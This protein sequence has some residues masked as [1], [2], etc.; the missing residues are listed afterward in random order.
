[1]T[2]SQPDEFTNFE[3]VQDDKSG[4]NPDVKSDLNRQNENKDVQETVRETWGGEFEFVLSL[5]GY[6]V[7]LGNIWRF[8]YFC[9]KNGGGCAIIPFILFLTVCGGPLYY[10]EVCLGQWSGTSPITVWNICPLLKGLGLLMVSLSLIYIWYYAAAFSWVIY[11]LIQSF[12]PTLPWSKCGNSWN[13]ELCIDAS[14]NITEKMLNMT[15]HGLNTSINF[16]TSGTEYFER[17]VLRKSSGIDTVGPVHLPLTGCFFLGWLFVFLCLAKG[18]KTLGKVVYVTVTLP[19]IL[20]TVLLIRGVTLDGAW[21]GLQHYFIPDFSKLIHGQVWMEAAV[22]CF[23]SLGPA[24]GGAITMASFNKFNH[25]A[26]RD[27]VVVCFADAFTGIYSGVVVFSV[28]GF[29]SKET[30]TPLNELPFSGASLAFIAYPEALSR[31]PAPHVWSVLFFLTLVLVGIDTQ[32]GCFETVT[33]AV[34]DLNYKKLQKYRLLISAGLVTFLFI[35]GL[36]LT[37]SAGYY[38]FMLIDSYMGT[39]NLVGTAL[40]ECIVIAWIYGANRFSADIEMMMGSRPSLILRIIWCFIIPVFLLGILIPTIVTYST[41]TVGDYKFPSHANIVG[42]VFAFAPISLIFIVAIYQV[43]RQRVSR[44]SVRNLLKPAS[45]WLPN[46]LKQRKIYK[47]TTYE[48]ESGFR[49][50]LLDNILGIK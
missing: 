18:V 30:G 22:Q 41:P 47:K 39:F 34:I 17:N 27:S 48:Y 13:T 26:L 44:K 49:F 25:N 23:F 11:F 45:C 2:E 35:T 32:F 37:T 40:L 46:D 19:Y 33:N 9:Y 28:L 12:F 14:T 8:P 42:N 20:L 50:R 21:N 6:T 38:I 24:W 31:L 16:R 29:L 15:D 5:V 10:M 1:M 4:L 7:G 43:I 36:P 3:I